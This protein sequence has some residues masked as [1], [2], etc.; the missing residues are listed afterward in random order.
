MGIFPRIRYIKVTTVIVVE[1]TIIGPFSVKRL[2][3][4]TTGIE[5]ERIIQDG[6]EQEC[7]EQKGV[8]RTRVHI[9]KAST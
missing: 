1:Q 2:R 6:I 3:H 7:I 9:T 8:D 4:K 5:Q